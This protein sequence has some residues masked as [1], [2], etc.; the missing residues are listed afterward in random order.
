MPASPANTARSPGKL[1]RLAL[2]AVAVVLAAGLA[3]A[4]LA[5]FDAGFLKARLEAAVL[6]ATGRTLAIGGAIHFTLLPA[7]GITADDVALG[8]IAGGSRPDMVRAASVAATFDP[9][10]LLGRRVVVRSLLLT[11]PDILVERAPD[12]RPNWV[13]S[14]PPRP[15]G[16]GGTTAA[17]RARFSLTIASLQVDG[18]RLTWTHVRRP[19][20]GGTFAIGRLVA[21]QHDAVSSFTLHLVGRHG[22]TPFTLSLASAPPAAL[23]AA[24]PSH[25]FP[26]RGS[27]LMGGGGAPDTL[28]LDG[29]FADPLHGRGFAGVVRVALRDTADLA[30]LFPHAGLPAVANLAASARLAQ[31]DGGRWA[32]SS[33]SATGRAADAGRILPG[34]RLARFSVDAPNRTAPIVV[35][36]AGTL[37]GQPV[38]LDA[39]A[40]GNVSFWDAAASAPAGNAPVSII[41]RA[42]RAQLRLDGTVGGGAD[43]SR[44][45]TAAGHVGV[46]DPA[47]LAALFG[48]TVDRHVAVAA[49]GRLAL[50]RSAGGDWSGTVG[51]DRL[52][53]DG[54]AMPSTEVRFDRSPVG[55]PE[56]KV[57]EGGAAPW[58]AWSGNVTGQ[59]PDGT[60]VLDAHRVPAALPLALAG[61][62]RGVSGP[63][64][65]TGTIHG[66]PAGGP[67]DPDRVSGDF[68]ATLVDGLVAKTLLGPALRMAHLPVETGGAQRVR[69]AGAT[70][71]IGGGTVTLTSLSLDSRLLAVDGAGT[72]ALARGGLALRLR[73]VVRLGG[74]AASAPVAVSGTLD[75][76]AVS[77]APDE[78]GR[79]AFSIGGVGAA[80]TRVACDANPDVA[81]LPAAKAPKAADILRSLG[82]FR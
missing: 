55:S 62:E 6:R 30:A 35:H 64:D 41:F 26:V 66:L 80:P 73:P 7:P 54:A 10:A 9:L 22:P 68:S 76:P 40:L 53:L 63:L 46:A 61:V 36:A 49:D 60:L 2:V 31:D 74:A 37:R 67:I 32:V 70:G 77:L 21:Q 65:L 42:P 82:L 50:Q 4:G 18:G 38:A 33:L 57:A 47:A 16:S 69:C 29:Q 17:P 25:P 52:L 3:V 13:F 72:I 34:L 5:R 58:L 23:A 44:T 59:P 81:A 71:R 48:R 1:R 27:L 79:V 20:D 45:L 51:L 12:G 56:V 78:R 43:G 19:G 39:P 11:R 28:A 24:G 15:A 75:A 8:N 14:P